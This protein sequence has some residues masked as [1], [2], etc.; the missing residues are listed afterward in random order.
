MDFDDCLT[1]Q[2]RTKIGVREYGEYPKSHWPACEWRNPD[3]SRAVIMPSEAPVRLISCNACLRRLGYIKIVHCNP[4]VE[5]WPFPDRKCEMC[6]YG[7]V[8]CETWLRVR[9]AGKDVEANLRRFDPNASH[10]VT[11]M[12]TGLIP[13]H[14]PNTSTDDL[15]FDSKDA[16]DDYCENLLRKYPKECEYL[17]SPPYEPSY[18]E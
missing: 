15:Y 6:D 4:R 8:D 2:Y 3:L 16:L 7:G 14:E 1:K 18:E 13:F 12:E 10:P 5:G 17:S 11:W 9:D